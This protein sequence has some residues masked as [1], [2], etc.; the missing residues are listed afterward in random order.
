[1]FTDKSQTQSA[2]GENQN[3]P[4]SSGYTA[5]GAGAGAGV[6]QAGRA[7]AATGGPEAFP[8]AAENANSMLNPTLDP[9]E[10]DPSAY[11]YPSMVGQGHNGTGGESY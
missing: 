8:G 10:Q 6:S 4:A 3:R 1:M 11:G 7:N 5:G 9:T 2:R